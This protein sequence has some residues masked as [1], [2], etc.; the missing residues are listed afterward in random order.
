MIKKLSSAKELRRVIASIGDQICD[1]LDNNFDI[2]VRTETEDIQGQKLAVLVNFLLEK[3]RRHIDKFKVLAE[4]QEEKIA[5]R[6]QILNLV[7]EGSSDTVWIWDLK[8]NKIEFSSHW[9]SLVSNDNYDGNMPLQ[10]WFNL[11]HPNDIVS[12]KAA[13]EEAKTSQKTQLRNEYRLKT[14]DGSYR[15]MLCRGACQ[16]DEHGNASVLAGTQTD[17]SELRS[18]DQASGL[19]NE[20]SLLEF[21]QDQLDQQ[22]AVTLYFIHVKQYSNL[23]Q[24]VEPE[25]V[26]PFRALVV[27]RLSTIAAKGTML[28]KLTGDIFAI[29]GTAD[30]KLTKRICGLIVDQFEQPF[31]VDYNVKHYLSVSVGAVGSTEI[32]TSSTTELLKC[33]S[34]ALRESRKSNG[35][36]VYD[37]AIHEKIA[38]LALVERELRKAISNGEL[39]VYLQPIVQTSTHDIVGFEALARFIHP[40]IGF[41]P[42]DEFIPIAEQSGL[43]VDLG[44]SVI[45]QSVQMVKKLQNGAM[46]GRAFYVAINVSAKQFEGHSLAN[47]VVS[48]LQQHQL[49]TSSIRL[50]VTETAIMQDMDMALNEL[51]ALRENGIKIALD[52]F[53]T[54]YSS[55]SYLQTLPIDVLKI[56]RSFVTDLDTQENKAAIIKTVFGLANLLSL[57]VVAEGVETEAELK[58]IESIGTMNIQ[59]Y[60]F[61]APLPWEKINAFIDSY[62]N[63]EIGSS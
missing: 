39:Q 3:V 21:L 22:Q 59:G 30:N 33:A 36:Y 12:L 11:V 40:T 2:H 28:A 10:N 53:G 5:E 1:T 9:N 63:I 32:S 56:D 20:S 18:R 58:T 46:Q 27:K 29:T 50:E 61:S 16:F 38:R 19:P 52:D 35:V 41:V 4:Q 60:Y 6:T 23:S 48:L 45:K 8:T 44:D 7:I 31:N 42:P 26:N 47:K 62:L 37:K 34:A 14:Q 43:M 54:G 13:I 25:M 55:L 17:I 24:L 51:S 49:P 57:D 15:W